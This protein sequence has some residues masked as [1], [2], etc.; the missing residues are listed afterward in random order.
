M[1]VTNTSPII[2]TIPMIIGKQYAH[3]ISLY[4]TGDAS[5]GII[6]FEI[7]LKLNLLGKYENFKHQI[8]KIFIEAPSQLNVTS[9]IRIPP[10]FSHFFPQNSQTQNY[11]GIKT[12][13][14][15]GNTITFINDGV[16]TRPLYIGKP[17]YKGASGIYTKIG[18]EIEPNTNTKIYKAYLE[19]E[20][21][22]DS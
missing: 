19:I 6:Y 13:E 17:T 9:H 8:N 11:I 2:K 3:L 12:T 1:S 18:I 16:L 22:E 21:W 14:I 20:S 5:G 4:E 7:D 10:A 15:S